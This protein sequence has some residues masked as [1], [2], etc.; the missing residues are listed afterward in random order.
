MKNNKRLFILIIIINVCL[1]KTNDV[2]YKI[3]DTGIVAPLNKFVLIKEGNKIGAFKF[4]NYKRKEAEYEWYYPLDQGGNK[5]KC[6]KRKVKD[7]FVSLIGR[8]AFQ[9]GNTRIKCGPL[10]LNWVMYNSICFYYNEE[11]KENHVVQLAP[12]NKENISDI[13]LNDSTLKW[14]RGS[15]RRREF[16][17]FLNDMSKEV[18][19][20]E[21]APQKGD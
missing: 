5:I 8:I 19:P 7:I 4:I 11:T 21:E 15:S 16:K 18:Y 3:Y 17:I 14:Y 10:K 2:Y 9:F 12:T 13:N 20:V 6:G 1:G